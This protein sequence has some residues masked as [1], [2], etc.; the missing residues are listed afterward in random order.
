MTKQQRKEHI[1]LPDK[2]QQST[3]SVHNNN[4]TKNANNL[5]TTAFH[6]RRPSVPS[7]SSCVTL[8]LH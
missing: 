4:C 7:K 8:Q 6:K 3:Y 1:K 2:L 5:H